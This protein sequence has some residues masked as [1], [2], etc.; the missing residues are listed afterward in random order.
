MMITVLSKIALQQSAPTSETMK[1]VKQLLNNWALQEDAILIYQKSDMKLAGHS[2]A[3]YLIG[4]KAYRRVAGHFFISN[5]SPF[6]PN[7]GAVLTV[8][9]TIK[10]F[11]TSAVEAELGSLFI[12]AMEAVYM[13]QI[14]KDVG[15]KQDWI[16]MQT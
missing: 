3:G 10:V 4:P 1:W 2:D 12:N 7:N 5:G 13:R 16:P 11:I 6:P 15:H 8:S 14:L 9:Q